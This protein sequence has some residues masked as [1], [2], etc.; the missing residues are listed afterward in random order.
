MPAVLVEIGFVSNKYEAKRLTNKSYL[1]KIAQGIADGIDHF[2][3]EY[4]YTKGF[5][6]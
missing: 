2:I 6:N 5:T 1:T 3:K 4:E